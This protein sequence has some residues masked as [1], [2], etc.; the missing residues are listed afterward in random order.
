[1]KGVRLACSTTVRRLWRDRGAVALIEFAMILPV[2]VLLAI[3]GAELT[4]YI[5]VKMRVSQI[6]LQIADNAGRM[7]S[8]SP[9]EAKKV[10]ETDINDVFSGAQVQ[11]G[12]LDLKTNGRVILSDLE[13][14]ALGST[15]YRIVWQRCYGNQPQSSSYGNTFSI[16][17]SGMGPAGRQVTASDTAPTMFVEVYYVYKPLVSDYWMPATAIREIASMSVRDRR[18]TSDDSLKGPLATHPQGIYKVSG[19]T[20]SSC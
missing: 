3:A 19:V 12:K 7:G 10:S 5:T 13:T 20:A 14:T 15:T 8:G 2:L 6:A 17:M 1:M 4:N 9:T 16:N 11:S 18:D